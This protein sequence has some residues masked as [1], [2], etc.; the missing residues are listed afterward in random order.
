MA[1]KKTSKSNWGGAR[2]GAGR[3]AG[4]P[5]EQFTIKHKKSVFDAL[6]IKYPKRGELHRLG[7]Q[8]LDSL[9]DNEPN[10]EDYSLKQ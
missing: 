6:K 4:E 5:A 10:K 1:T 8:W 3:P 2:L 9:L 7:R